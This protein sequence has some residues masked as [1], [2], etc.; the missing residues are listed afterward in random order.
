VASLA[1]LASAAASR[2]HPLV[3]THKQYKLQRLKPSPQTSHFH[4]AHMHT[5]AHT[6]N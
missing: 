4:N 1:S 2:L 5:Q 3:I 6:H